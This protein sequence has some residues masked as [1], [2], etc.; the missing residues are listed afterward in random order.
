VLVRD[1]AYGQIPRASR[2]AKHGAAAA[3][4]E[5][6]GGTEDSAEMLA[7]HYLSALE[8]AR[9]SGHETENLAQSARLALRDAG[10]RASGLSGFAAAARL[11]G[12]SLDLWPA[13][14]PERAVV[15]F[16]QAKAVYRLG[17]PPADLLTEALDALDA[18][19]DRVRSAE[20]EIMLGHS[21]WLQGK[22]DLGFQH[23]ERAGEMVEELPPSPTKA[24]VLVSISRFLGLA[25]E[26]DDAIRIGLAGLEMAQDLGLAELGAEALNNV[27]MAR[28]SS[29]E[30]EGLADLEKS[31]AIAIEI[32]SPEAIRAYGNLSSTV[33][34]EGDLNRSFRLLNEAM[35][36]A[37]RF[38]HVRYLRWARAE[39]VSERYYTG[40]WDEGLML[41]EE[42]FAEVEAT[43][44]PYF[45]EPAVHGLRARILL[46]RG[47]T[48]SAL[49]EM[50]KGLGKARQSKDPQNLH[51]ALALC[52]RVAHAAG[53]SDEAEPLI[54]E[55]LE[56]WAEGEVL[57]SASW[58]TDLACALSALGRGDEFV[59]AF[60][61]ARIQ[62]RWLD[63]A[64]AYAAGDPAKAADTYA[65]MGSLPDEAFARLQAA[66][67]LLSDG[68]R[69]DADA[70]LGRALAFHRSVGATRY[71][72]EGEA[73]AAA[74]A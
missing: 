34:D 52:A 44:L 65:E 7:H 27:G 59:E 1:V 4:I 67:A 53:R 57:F 5:S 42:F 54:A 41:A 16:N 24:Y 43:G 68:R 12:A 26:A 63:A 64:A 2:A 11:Y 25:G 60:R 17:D 28:A 74:S 35:R 55:L 31:V 71:V 21:F 23:F 73:L 36:L 49:D 45:L 61:G 19:G 29:G 46:G 39:R 14:D 15:L 10:D 58:T 13:E 72:R 56:S 66:Q 62:T 37:E 40:R 18:A 48:A 70:Q 51:P 30:P 9:A 8:F 20:T 38:G 22:R 6:L 47:D 69:A 32:N 33:H 3:W 50:R